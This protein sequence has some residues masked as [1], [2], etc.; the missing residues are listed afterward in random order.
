MDNYDGHKEQ[1]IDN[2]L[3]TFSLHLKQKSIHT[4]KLGKLWPTMN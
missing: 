1:M 4:F 2:D 3:R